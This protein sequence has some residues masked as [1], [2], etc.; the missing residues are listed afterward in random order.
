MDNYLVQFLFTTI[1][2]IIM[3]LAANG[4]VENFLAFELGC[5][6]GLILIWIFRKLVNYTNRKERMVEQ[7]H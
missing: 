3:L 7:W 6:I 2:G 5:T 4:S 1:I